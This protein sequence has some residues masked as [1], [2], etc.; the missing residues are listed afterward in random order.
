[1]SKFLNNL[2]AKKITV[3]P[4]SAIDSFKRTPANYF[5]YRQKPFSWPQQDSDRTTQIDFTDMCVQ[6][7]DHKLGFVER[8]H[9]IDATAWIKHIA[10]V[11]SLGG[12]RT[13]IGTVLARAYAHELRT[14]YGINRIIFQEDHREFKEAGY[15]EYFASIGATPMSI[16]HGQL[17]DRPDFEW[18]ECKWGI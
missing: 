12:K 17:P 5:T 14:R 10:V 7:C 6:V 4:K 16:K 9:C 15:P 11:K 3:D 13:K 18:L 1:M 2:F 8:V